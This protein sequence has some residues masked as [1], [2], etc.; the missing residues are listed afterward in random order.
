M[1]KTSLDFGNCAQ[2]QAA[3]HTQSRAA[4]RTLTP[5]EKAISLLVWLQYPDKQICDILGMSRPTL[6]GHIKSLFGKLAVKSRVGLALTHERS[7][8]STPGKL[9]P[10]QIPLRK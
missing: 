9:F 1:K 6:R 7:L 8:H 10:W 5:R 3:L 4:I 2:L